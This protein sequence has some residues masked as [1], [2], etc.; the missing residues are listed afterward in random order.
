MINDVVDVPDS[1]LALSI[2]AAQDQKLLSNQQLR[3]A[4]HAAGGA[5]QAQQ[6]AN[7][8]LRALGASYADACRRTNELR[9]K[10]QV[11]KKPGRTSRSQRAA[12]R[13]WQQEQAVLSIKT[14][15]QAAQQA[16]LARANQL[17]AA[18]QG[19]QQIPPAPPAQQPPPAAP[20]RDHQLAFDP[21]RKRTSP[22]GFNNLVSSQGVPRATAGT[23]TGR[24]PAAADVVPIPPGVTPV[25]TRP[26]TKCVRGGA[27]KPHILDRVTHLAPQ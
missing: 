18:Q 25:Q 26:G 11:H 8:E 2:Q 5:F 14:A 7:P 15:Q 20:D 23:S 10:Q 12:K 13:A 17:L 4:V 6:S 9:V 22:R 21:S 3:R 1:A 16:K 19:Q 24:R 27:A